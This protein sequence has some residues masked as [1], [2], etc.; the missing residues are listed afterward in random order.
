[1]KEEIS[2]KNMKAVILA[3]VSTQ[4]QTQGESI[5]GQTDRLL[6]YCKRKNLQIIK[7]FSI[8]ESST[9]GDRKEFQEVIEFIKQQKQEIALVAEAVDRIQRGFKES[10]LLSDMIQLGQVCLHFNKENL[11]I[12]QNSNP[13]EI[14]RW[15]FSVLGAKS[16]ALDI[17]H[18]TKRSLLTK[19]QKGELTRI[20]PIGYLNIKDEQEKSKII[21]DK[22][23][24]FLVKE[25]FEMYSTGKFAIGDLKKF[26]KENNLTN[27][28]FKHKEAKPVS[29][30][31]I[32][33]MLSNSFY[34]G[35]IYVKKYDRFYPHNYDVFITRE[36][37][38]RCQLVK[39]SRAEKNNRLQIT[40]QTS[41]KKD[42]VFRGLLKC[43]ITGRTISSDI[44]KGKHIYLITWN[45][46]N[47]SKKIYVNENKILNQV[48][49]IFKSISIPDVLLEQITKHLQDSHT[50]EKE[51]HYHKIEQINKDE[52]KIQEKLNELLD[53]RLEKSISQDMFEKKSQSLRDELV[54]FNVEKQIHQNAD[55][56]FKNTIATAFTLASKAYDIFE[57]SKITEKRNLIAFMFSNLKLNGEK[58]V[59]TL[60]K[61]FDL[62]VNLSQQPTWLP[63]QDSNLRPIG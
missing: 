14:L 56:N 21:V 1:M 36:L 53:M 28:F 33:Q 59:F 25:M 42:F 60:K 63:R 61:P 16:Y 55:N 62:M 13:S 52:S 47:P 46:K 17:S 44:K 43:D 2:N 18:N 40:Q 39:K 19:L 27:T 45:P 5:N 15:D 29:S 26:A 4:E 38:D 32:T 3:R 49:D 12:N 22:S 8:V 23:R 20:A 58:L 6:E 48:K 34:Y 50:A 9:K 11:V 10:V 30:S 35:E 7:S 57:S 31:V 51:Y 37:F 54:K 41:P 24:A